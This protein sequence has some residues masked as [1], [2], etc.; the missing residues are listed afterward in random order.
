MVLSPFLEV[1]HL[2]SQLFH[3]NMTSF[4]TRSVLFY[5]PTCHVGDTFDRPL[6]LRSRLLKIKTGLITLHV[7]CSD[8]AV[9]SPALAVASTCVRV[10]S[11]YRVGL[12]YDP[13]KGPQPLLLGTHLPVVVALARIL[14]GS[15]FF[16]MHQSIIPSAFFS[17]PLL[18]FLL[19][20]STS[21]RV[22][23]FVLRYVPALS[24]L[25]CRLHLVAT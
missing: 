15:R 11:Y 17:R 16:S 19:W 5:Q 4:G 9:S 3:Q 13:R 1:L 14:R 22:L 6:G 24:P 12:R 2:R 23:D 10:R 21:R 20:V 8:L 25:V 18:C 7:V